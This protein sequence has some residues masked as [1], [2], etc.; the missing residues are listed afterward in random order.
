MYLSETNFLIY[1]QFS[2]SLL[3]A[4]IL[5]GKDI[6]VIFYLFIP[7]YYY[8]YYYY[9]YFV[10]VRKSNVMENPYDKSHHYGKPIT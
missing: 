4:L 5:G 8:Y 10:F 2:K 3:G 7:Y 1:N 6:Y 9:Y